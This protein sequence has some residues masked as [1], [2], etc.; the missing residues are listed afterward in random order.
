MKFT[1]LTLFPK[2]IEGFLHESIIKRA[3]EKKLVEIKVVNI[4]D[5]ALD[6]YGTVDGRPYGGGAGMVLRVDVLSKVF[7]RLPQP[8]HTIL[9]SAKGRQYSQADAKRL[10]EYEHIV[11]LAGHY[12]GVDERAMQYVDEEISMGDFILTGGE[13]VCATLL[14]SIVRLIPGVLKKE[15]ATVDESFFTVPIDILIQATGSHPVLDQLII[16][17]KNEVQLL[18]YPHYTRPEDYEGYKVPEVL[19]SGDPK[20]IKKWQLLNAFEQ[21]LTKRPDLLK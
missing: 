13:L 2:M 14:D 9:T 1:I 15:D 19:L 6:S 21:T 8:R 10:S 12:E 18:E 3:Q 4:R 16:K 7:D 20:K 11:L 5:F 17:G